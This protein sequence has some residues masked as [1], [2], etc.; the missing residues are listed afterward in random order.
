LTWSKP[1]SWTGPGLKIML[2]SIFF[3]FF[4]KIIIETCLFL[5]SQS[6]TFCSFT[7]QS[8]LFHSTNWTQVKIMISSQNN[9]WIVHYSI[10]KHRNGYENMLIPIYST[11]PIN[12]PFLL[13]VCISLINYLKKKNTTW[14]VKKKQVRKGQQNEKWSDSS[15]RSLRSALKGESLPRRR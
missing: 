7:Y 10:L 12:V 8:F 13:S 6:N 5:Y 9:G 2:L 3:F 1:R 15:E 4:W 14:N 11:L